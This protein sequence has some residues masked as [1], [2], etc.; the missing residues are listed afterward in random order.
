V[1]S[2][3]WELEDKSSPLRAFFEERLPRTAGVLDAATAHPEGFTTKP[4]SR[5]AASG[6]LTAILSSA[7]VVDESTVGLESYPWQTVG[8][9]F[10]YRLR[11]FFDA[12]PIESLVAYRGALALGDGTLPRSFEELARALDSVVGGSHPCSS[13]LPL[14]E[15]RA[16]CRYCYLLALFEQL[17]RAGVDETWGIVRHGRRGGL[18]EVASL[19]QEACVDDLVELG[20]R[21]TE[22]QGDLLAETHFALNPKFATSAFIG[23]DADLIVGRRLID[24]KTIKTAS[25]FRKKSRRHVWQLVG[26]VLGDSENSYELSEAGFYLSRQGVQLFWRLDEL[27]ERLAGRPVDLLELRKAFADA[28]VEVALWERIGIAAAQVPNPEALTRA[29]S[30]PA[31]RCVERSLQF[32]PPLSKGG[33]WHVSCADSRCVS[34]SEG[35]DPQD[36][37]SCGSPVSLDTAADGAWTI[38]GE[39]FRDADARFC[40]RCLIHTEAFHEQWARVLEERR[41][42][43]DEGDHSAPTVDRLL[44]FYPPASGKGRWHVPHTENP[45]ATYYGLAGEAGTAPSCGSMAQLDDQAEPIS[46]P[47][48]QSIQDADPRLCRHC[49]A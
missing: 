27:L 18:L 7:R 40:R 32:L 14:A 6:D 48:D 13:L 15:E 24:V 49:L 5:S 22:T 42:L 11:Y 19:C 34:V 38:I 45:G 36:T 44:K 43:G 26:Y 46:P 28:C 31:P 29:A 8:T 33:K 39:D 37:P 25:D 10:D 16:L 4:A 41:A 21:F 35:C 12:S 17:A 23:M 9:A 3:K 47:K 30:P 1:S 20:R 2:L